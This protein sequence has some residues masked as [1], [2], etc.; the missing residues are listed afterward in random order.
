MEHNK[1]YE[2]TCEESSTPKVSQIN[3]S[4]DYQM[5]ALNALND[6]INI[7]SEILEPIMR[8]DDIT[9]KSKE[10][11]EASPQK[12]A[13]SEK[14]DELTRLIHIQLKRISNMINLCEL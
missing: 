7:L 9:E 14:I 11:N 6:K 2:N 8:Q 10:Q 4:L 5:M 12:V 13:L 3:A 1:S